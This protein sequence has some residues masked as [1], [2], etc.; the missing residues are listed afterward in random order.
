MFESSRARDNGADVSG[1]R[2]R[3]VAQSLMMGWHLVRLKNL[4]RIL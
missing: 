2:R 4:N 3:L 1:N